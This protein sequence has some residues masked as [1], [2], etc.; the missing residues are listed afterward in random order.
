MYFS[1]LFSFVFEEG[2]RQGWKLNPIFS[3]S[4]W[5]QC[6]TQRHRTLNCRLYR[7]QPMRRCLSGSYIGFKHSSGWWGPSG[8]SKAI[9]SKVR[10]KSTSGTCKN[11]HSRTPHS[12]VPLW[13]VWATPQECMLLQAPGPSEAPKQWRAPLPS[14]PQLPQGQQNQSLVRA[15]VAFDGAWRL[16]GSDV[17]GAVKC[18]WKF[19]ILIW[20][21]IWIVLKLAR[22]L[23]F[24]T[25]G[26][27]EHQGM[28]DVG[29]GPALMP[30][31]LYLGLFCALCLSEPGSGCHVHVSHAGSSW[32]LHT[33]PGNIIILGLCFLLAWILG[34][35][36]RCTPQRK[37][38]NR[39]CVHKP[40]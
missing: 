25:P 35:T 30:T 15:S 33:I 28:K 12:E 7:N 3:V 19:K 2:D 18:Q 37:R 10:R 13:E 16:C 34:F 21:T 4:Y 6:I 29:S 36:T 1:F 14:G 27:S 22:L 38:C 11:T 9:W 32:L 23:G 5:W 40:W 31:E 26:L 24:S 17:R 39:R 8:V 20:G